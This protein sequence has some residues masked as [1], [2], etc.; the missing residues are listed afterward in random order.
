[1]SHAATAQL[2]TRRLLPVVAFGLGLAYLPTWGPAMARV[3]GFELQGGPLIALWLNWVAAG[4]LLAYVRVVERR[5]LASLLLTRPSSKDLEYAVW[6]WGAVMT[7][8]WVIGLL[9]PQPPN[10][11]VATITALPVLAVAALVVT[12][13]VTE[14]LLMRAYPIER[15]TD[16]TGRRWIGVLVSALIFVAPHLTFFS[17]DWLLYQGPGAAALY[18]LYLWRRNLYACMVLHLL[19]NAPILIPTIL[20]SAGP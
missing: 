6:A 12:T 19:I 2:P 9:R 10:E 5:P 11:G 7:Y 16:L 8:S 18:G 14:E 15:L 4:L 3:T 1:V 17:L 13:A 20:R